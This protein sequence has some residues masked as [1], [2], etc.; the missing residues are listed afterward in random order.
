[1]RDYTPPPFPPSAASPTSPTA[2]PAVAFDGITKRF[3][4]VTA[5]EDISFEVAEGSIH[6]VVGENGAG[7]STLMHV[8]FGLVRPDAGTVRLRGRR[9]RFRSPQEA[10]R[11]GVGMIHQHFSLVPAFSVVENVVLGR[12][13]RTRWGSID[14]PRAAARVRELG[15]RHGLPVEPRTLVSAL[16]IAGQQRVEILKALY[17]GARVLVLD[18]PTTVLGAAE[19]EQLQKTVRA[20]VAEGGTV[21]YITHRLPEVFALCDQV[22]LLRRGRVVTTRPTKGLPPEAL[23]QMLVGDGERPGGLAIR[24]PAGDVLVQLAN[25]ST[26]ARPGE[27]GLDDVSLHVRSGE[28]VG[29]AGVA[30]NGQGA[31]ARVLVGA[32]SPRQGR[33]RLRTGRAYSG[34]GVRA[35]RRAGVGWIPADRRTDGLVA[36]LTLADNLILGRHTRPPYA[37]LGVRRLGV[38]R[39]AAREPVRRLRIQPGGP[40]V[41]AGTLSGGNQQKLLASRELEATPRLLV[42]EH[43]TRGVDIGAA[44]LIHQEM[45]NACKSGAGIVVISADLEE[46]LK[47]SDRIVVLYGGRIVH[48]TAADQTTPVGLAAYLGGVGSGAAAT[49]IG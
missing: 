42:A 35:R 25:V 29:I 30:G 31:L 20:I 27:A 23:A 13:P 38:V 22:T 40:T 49:E 7:K 4:P 45:S 41:L 14:W 5:N 16:D 26:P 39:R 8:L 9:V 21:L 17:R 19:F 3:G 34:T 11:A 18:E 2:P 46:L 15:E 12:E 36:D 48:E 28:I 43:P 47:L 6:A 24:P 32:E 1:M 10:I 33:V 37:S 44:G